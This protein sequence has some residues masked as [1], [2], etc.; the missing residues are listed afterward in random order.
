[1]TAAAIKLIGYGN[2]LLQAWASDVWSVA[3]E[4][5][6]KNHVI[7]RIYDDAL[8]KDAPPAGAL[9]LYAAGPPCQAFSTAGVRRP[10]NDGRAKHLKAAVRVL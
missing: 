9:L 4:T 2:K 6:R 10:L 8:A 3:R 5:M 1:M 7:N